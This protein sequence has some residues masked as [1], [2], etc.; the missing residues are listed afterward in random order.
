MPAMSSRK[1]GSTGCGVY[2]TSAGRLAS[3]TECTG[4]AP[5]PCGLVSAVAI[6]PGNALLHAA[7]S[8]LAHLCMLSRNL[9]RSVLLVVI[10][11]TTAH[12]ALSDGGLGATSTEDM[13]AVVRNKSKSQDR[14][15]ESRVRSVPNCTE[16]DAVQKCTETAPLWHTSG[17]VRS[18]SFALLPA[19]DLR[20]RGTPLI[21]FSPSNRRP[22]IR[23][24]DRQARRATRK[25][26]RH[27]H[28]MHENVR[29]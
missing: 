16:P 28:K 23:T 15:N 17:T 13:I 18:T 8:G 5:Q 20:P 1:D 2:T 22:G 21:L 6:L 12:D 19:G 29:L 14:R 9:A 3:A 4:T 25:P 27:V 7:N 10:G 24:R 26:L 11:I